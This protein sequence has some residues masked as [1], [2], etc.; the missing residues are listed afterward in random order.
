MPHVMA[1]GINI[2]YEIH[3][4]GDPL[5]LINP[6]GYDLWIWHRMVP[7]LAKHFQV[8]TF[9][10]RGVGQTDKPPGPYTA[11]LL[12][13]DSV[14]LLAALNIDQAAVMGY[15]MGGFVAQELVLSRPELV[16][17][18][19]LSATDCGG[20]NHIPVTPEAMAILINVDLDPLER[21]WGGFAVSTAPGFTETN[22]DLVQS[23]IDYR[24][25]H[26]VEPEAYQAQLAIGLALRAAPIEECFQPRLKE[27]QV[28]TLILWGEHDMVEPP[29]N[30]ELLAKE[31]PNSTLKILP[32]AGHLL[33]LEAPE[34]TV[35][36]MVAFLN[37]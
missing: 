6:I 10:N 5:L 37:A 2:Y 28:P 12:A 25:T 20:P 19:I 14:A 17:Q 33:P 13:D 16:S 35:A 27:A 36:A 8:V 24:A 30:G 23:W 31:I 7:A 22:R 15:S 32:N 18:L 21:A 1:N 4:S 3:G 29:G 11:R 26:P 9:D 34:A